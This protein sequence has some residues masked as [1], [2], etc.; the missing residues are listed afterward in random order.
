MKL[1]SL[2]VLVRRRTVTSK[3]SMSH[4]SEPI[5]QL[6]KGVTISARI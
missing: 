1:F 6:K 4:E 2:V 5:I 3:R